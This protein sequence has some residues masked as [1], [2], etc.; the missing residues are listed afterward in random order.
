MQLALFMEKNNITNA[1]MAKR[2]GVTDGFISKLKKFKLIPSLPIA[3]CIIDASNGEI[4]VRDLISQSRLDSFCK[5][6]GIA[7]VKLS[8]MN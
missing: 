7:N 5:E 4:T 8:R 1:Q 2:L 6:R 3:I